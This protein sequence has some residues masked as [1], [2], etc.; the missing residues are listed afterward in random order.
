MWQLSVA[1]SSAAAAAAAAAGLAG[2]WD[3]VSLLVLMTPA[4]RILSMQLKNRTKKTQKH[5]QFKR[6]DWLHVTTAVGRWTFHSAKKLTWPMNSRILAFDTSTSA[7]WP[8]RN[9]CSIGSVWGIRTYSR[10]L[11]TICWSAS[12]HS[13]H[14]NEQN[15]HLN[16]ITWSLWRKI[17]KQT[18]QP[19]TLSQCFLCRA[20]VGH[21][22]RY[23]L[24]FVLPM[25]NAHQ[26]ST[27]S[28]NWSINGNQWDWEMCTASTRASV[29]WCQSAYMLAGL[30]YMKELTRA[31]LHHLQT[32]SFN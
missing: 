2:G 8:Q 17:R 18:R 5:R 29:H 32:V 14:I 24:S 28:D 30:Q 21:Q 9:S 16:K 31:R 20:V 25:H 1:G 4:L 10:Y 22:L 13:L 3:G 23:M 19:C 15:K 6:S 12:G 7:R 27:E 26:T 11:K